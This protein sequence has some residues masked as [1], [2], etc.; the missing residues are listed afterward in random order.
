VLGAEDPA[1]WDE[2]PDARRVEPR[3]GTP[4]GKS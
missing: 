3:H 1:I 2:L 4:V